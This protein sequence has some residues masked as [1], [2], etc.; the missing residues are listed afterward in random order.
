MTHPLTPAGNNPAGIAPVAPTQP[1]RPSLNGGT[2]FSEVLQKTSGAPDA[3]W[4]KQLERA[5]A[6]FA[7]AEHR[8][9]QHVA[10]L[11][12]GRDIEGPR[13]VALQADVYHHSLQLELASKLVDKGTDAVRQ[14]LRSQT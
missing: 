9:Q 3:L 7:G 12:Q 13:L 5:V 10:R 4:G 6:D 11:R 1:S 2:T 14:T 8:L